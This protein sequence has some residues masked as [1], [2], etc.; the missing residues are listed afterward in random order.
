MGLFYY[1]PICLCKK[2][3]FLAFVVYFF[4]KTDNILDFITGLLLGS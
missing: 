1:D 4:Y 3:S 2:S